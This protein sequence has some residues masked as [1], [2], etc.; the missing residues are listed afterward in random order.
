M[1]KHNLKTTILSNR[2]VAEDH[3]LL[4][5]D[6]PEVAISAQPGQFIHVLFD[7]GSGLLLRRPFT[8]Y[9]VEGTQISMLYQVV[10]EG[11][12]ILSRMCAGDSLQ[13]LGPLGNS[14]TIDESLDLAVVLG[15]GAGIAS[16]MLLISALQKRKIRTDVLVGAMNQA[17]LLSIADLQKIGIQPQIAT[18]NGSTGHHGFVT[19]LLLTTLA[20]QKAQLPTVFTCGPYGM[21]KAVTEI[22]QQFNMPCQ[23]AMENR[24]GCAL[25]VC[26][27]CVCK[28]RLEGGGQDQSGDLLFEYQRVCTEGPV[29]LGQQIIW[30]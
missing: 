16:L 19:E 22:C 21:L 17:R 20:Q 5:F 18:D 24:M 11:T 27:G 12:S 14:F 29:F 26:L 13:V 4:Y 2:Q 6:C 15:G 8:I 9:S 3:Y 23:V 7:Q 28:V 25:G 1:K 10:G 30:D